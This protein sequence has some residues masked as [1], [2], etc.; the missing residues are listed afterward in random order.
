[1]LMYR[2]NVF[3]FYFISIFYFFEIKIGIVASFFQIKTDPNQVIKQ[4][5]VLKKL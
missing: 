5:C 3:S 1:M 2:K 4:A